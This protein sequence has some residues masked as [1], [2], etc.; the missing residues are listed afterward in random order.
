MLEAIVC[1]VHCC[2][3]CPDSGAVSDNVYHHNLYTAP[4]ASLHWKYFADCNKVV[5][6]RQ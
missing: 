6:P 4:P 1:P 3:D 2:M 5:P